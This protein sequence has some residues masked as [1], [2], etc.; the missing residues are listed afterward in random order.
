LVDHLAGRWQVLEA[1]RREL[2]GPAPDG[3][4]LDLRQPV[5]FD[6]PAASYGPWVQ[7]DSGEE[8]LQRDPPTRRYGVGVLYPVRTPGGTA[9]LEGGAD[10]TPDSPTDAQPANEEVLAAPATAA[11]RT[12]AERAPSGEAADDDLDLSAANDYQPSAMAL[13]FLVELPPDAQ[14]KVDVSGGRYEPVAVHVAGR[15]RTWWLR[16]PVSVTVLFEP[17]DLTSGGTRMVRPR[18]EPPSDEGGPRL[19]VRAFTR[20]RSDGTALVTVSLANVA[21]PTGASRANDQFTLF[22]AAFSVAVTDGNGAGLIRPYPSQE[23]HRAAVADDDARSFE[24]LYRKAQT[25][26]IGHGCAADW[27]ARWGAETSATVRAES[28]PAFETPSITP[29]V[30]GEDGAELRVSMARLAGL[31]ATDDGFASV[32]AI[33]SGYAVWIERLDPE[34]VPLQLQETARA[35][36]ERCAATLRRMRDGLEFIRSDATALRA[37]QLANH[38]VLLQQ[39]RTRPTARP[40]T[41][42]A[43]TGRFRM[44]EPFEERDWRTDAERGY[45]RPFQIAFLLATVR[46]I[47][48]GSD[49]DRDTVELVFFPTGGGKTEAYLGQTAFALFNRRLND[50]DDTGVEVLMRYTLRLLTAQ[51]FLRAAALICAMERLRAAASDLGSEPFSIGIWLGGS[52]TPNRRA[53]ARAQLSAL[54]RAD[55]NAPNPFLLLRCPWCSAQ[56]GPVDVAGRRTRGR[57]GPATPSVAGYL[58][59]GGSVAFRCPDPGCDFST[60][61]LPVYVIDEDIYDIRPSLV[62]GTVDKFALLAW[63]PEARALFGIGADG[64][65]CA[66]PPGLIIQDE[67]HLISGPLGSMVGLYEGVIEDLATDKRPELP[68]RPK[69]VAS[70]A[71]IRRFE[72]QVKGLYARNRVALF[73]PHGFDASDSFFGRYAEAADGR[74]WAPGRIYLG[75]HAPGLGSVQTAQVRTSASLLQAAQDLRED[76]RDPWFTLLAFFNS[77]R[78]LGTTL[79]LLQSDI[80]DYLGVLRNRRGTDWAAVRRLRHIMEL[81]SRLRDDEVPDAIDQLQRPA[82]AGD[83]VDVCLS[84]SI[85]EVGIDIDRLSLI[86]LLGQPKSTSQYIQVTGRIGR[87]W[88]ER[89]GLAVVIYSASKPRDRSHFE[90][91]RTYHERLYAQVEPTSVTPFAP[92]VLTRALHAVVCGHVRQNGVLGLPPWPMP[93]GLI[94]AAAELLTDRVERVDPGEAQH[95]EDVLAERVDEWRAWERTE[96][97]ATRWRETNQAPLLRRAGQWVPPFAARV[98]WPTPTSMRNVD[99]ECRAEVTPLY[100]IERAEVEVD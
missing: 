89:P 65:R 95:M 7:L 91:F 94:D 53:E 35:H 16:R 43:E 41:I 55:R 2:V 11:V 36:K 71:T 22:Q 79:S 68:I 70:T 88:R 30:P 51:Q 67:L 37:F 80:P 8:V 28:L 45:W 39:L 27:D 47:A 54:S 72:S 24:L 64:V 14:F 62:I 85:I 61:R 76:S 87:R 1:L 57:R 82:S 93:E 81:T 10:G 48:D 26:A 12:I 56:M 96:W 3:R 33:I 73:P 32:E 77:L 25:F 13:S 98:S 5:H 84:S 52:T 99:A 63:R 4:P 74:G 6:D 78:E 21:R 49:R 23:T 75:V 29:D 86:C 97:S 92:P 40:T 9:V 46:S 31:D 18:E 59:S 44:S 90:R 60:T 100:A 66:S 83:A 50:P 38:A 15:D 20:P 69:I 58:S 42:D 34:Q 17:A 19:Q